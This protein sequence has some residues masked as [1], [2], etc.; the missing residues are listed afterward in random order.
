M[1]RSVAYALTGIMLAGIAAW[2]V[3]NRW[4][5]E[6]LSPNPLDEVDRMMSQ[7]RNKLGEIQNNLTEF[8]HVLTQAANLEQSAQPSS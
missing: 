4:T 7:T 8:R 3:R 1:N 6:S 2:I 5:G